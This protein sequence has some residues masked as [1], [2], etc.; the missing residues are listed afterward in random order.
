MLKTIR[1][2][3]A[4]DFVLGLVLLFPVLGPWMMQFLNQFFTN[5]ELLIN[6]YHATLMKLLGVMV[7]LWAM[8]RLQHTAKW[9]I[10][11]DCTARLVV[12]GVLLYYWMQGLSILALFLLVE[13]LGLYQLRY[14]RYC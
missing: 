6:P 14:R 2:F 5:E 4:V 8:V 11:Y 7:I 13:C 9:Q 1:L 10:G 12:I 3:A